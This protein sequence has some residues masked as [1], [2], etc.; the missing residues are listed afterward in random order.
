[1]TSLVGASFKTRPG[2][3]VLGG[4]NMDGFLQQTPRASFAG[5][6]DSLQ[7]PSVYSVLQLP[8]KNSMLGTCYP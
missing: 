3:S 6:Q 8:R 1:M 4:G 5:R 2:N 7:V